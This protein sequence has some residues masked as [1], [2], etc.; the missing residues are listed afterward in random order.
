LYRTPRYWE[1]A[2]LQQPGAAGGGSELVRG[3]SLL[4]V[5]QPGDGS[6]NT[7]CRLRSEYEAAAEWLRGKRVCVWQ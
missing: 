5:D 3:A 1:D 2:T 7:G 4:Q 6:R